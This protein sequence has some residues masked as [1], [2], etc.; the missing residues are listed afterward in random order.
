M[1]MVLQEVILVAE[2]L[3]KVIS[4][5]TREASAEMISQEEALYDEDL[6]I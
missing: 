2:V 4:R 6:H 1:M 3:L 5:A